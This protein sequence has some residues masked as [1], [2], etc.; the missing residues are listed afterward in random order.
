[1]P[2][3]KS[4]SDFVTDNLFNKNDKKNKLEIIGDCLD[5]VC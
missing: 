2:P 4:I 5:I 1:M 3:S